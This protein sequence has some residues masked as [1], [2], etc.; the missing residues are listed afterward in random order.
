[1]KKASGF[2]QVLAIII[3]FIPLA[4]E[5]APDSS[6]KEDLEGTDTVDLDADPKKDEKKDDKKVEETKKTEEEKK[7]EERKKEREEQ[8]KKEKMKKKTKGK[9]GKCK[10]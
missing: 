8:K 9:K 5:E 1:M 6:P 10:V 2:F 7:N 3:L 4:A